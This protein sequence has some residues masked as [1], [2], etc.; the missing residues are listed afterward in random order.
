[1]AM[2]A[3]Q[4]MPWSRATCACGVLLPN[5][6][7]VGVDRPWTRRAL[8]L[9]E[10]AMY[11]SSYFAGQDEQRPCRTCRHYGG[12][13]PDPTRCTNWPRATSS[14]LRRSPLF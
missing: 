6:R 5:G 1:M 2:T 10:S 4:L 8:A 3:A 7:F 13:L 14:S 11:T 9:L 12:P